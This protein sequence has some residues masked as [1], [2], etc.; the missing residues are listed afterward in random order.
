MKKTLYLSACAPVEEKGGIY[1][2]SLE[3]GRLSAEAYYPCDRP[4]YTVID[5][6]RLHVILRQVKGNTGGYFS[7]GLDFENPSEMTDS[8][9]IV[10][11]HLAACGEEVWW[12][13]YLSGN[14]VKNDGSI[15]ERSGS[16][17]N[18]ARQDMPHTHFVQPLDDRF[19]GVCD[20]GTDTLAVYDRALTLIT[21]AHVPAGYGI[22]HFV[23]DTER[24]RIYS[25]NELVPSVSVFSYK[26]GRIAYHETAALPC[27]SPAASGAAIRLSPDGRALYVSVREEN[28][29]F[30]LDAGEEIA[31][32]A[33]LSCS[34]DSP[35]DFMPV[36]GYLVCTN[37]K[38]NSVTVITPE[39]VCA[40]TLHLPAPLCV[41]PL[42]E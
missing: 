11:C 24:G 8:R 3:D 13:N 31:V 12:V 23:Q 35:R 26:D 22:R 39:G 25:V 28:A 37:E 38:S 6:G 14:I 21:E 40:D 34:G 16:G 29:V 1:R 10:P 9:G 5:G 42:D 41:T 27:T 18:A 36:C 4:M 32:K 30:V 33:K 2:C 15:A 17:P 20:L 19:L 7:I